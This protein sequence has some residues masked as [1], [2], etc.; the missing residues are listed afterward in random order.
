MT[1][2]IKLELLIFYKILKL[3]Y[4][5]LGICI[6][7]SNGGI[8]PS[9]IQGFLDVVCYFRKIMRSSFSSNW[10]TKFEVL[11]G[12]EFAIYNNLERLPN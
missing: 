7:I 6:V 12:G 4:N 3:V 5:I 11:N 8:D 9:C 10:N 1:Y 2:L